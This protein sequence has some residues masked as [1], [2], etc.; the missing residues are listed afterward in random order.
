MSKIFR[1]ELLTYSYGITFTWRVMNVGTSE[2]PEMKYDM[3]GKSKFESDAAKWQTLR[4]QVF[5]LCQRKK[6]APCGEKISKKYIYQQKKGQS[7]SKNIVPQI[8]PWSSEKIPQPGDEF[9]ISTPPYPR[10]VIAVGYDPEH[11]PFG[12][13]L[14]NATTSSTYIDVVCGSPGQLLLRSFIDWSGKRK[15]RLSSILDVIQ[16]YP[17]FGFEFGKCGEFTELTEKVRSY[18]SGTFSDNEKVPKKAQSVI[19]YMRRKKLINP[20]L[21]NAECERWGTDAFLR[22][23][24]FDNGVKMERCRPKEF[25]LRIKD[26]TLRTPGRSLRS[27][28][29][30]SSRTRSKRRTNR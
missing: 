29:P 1:I 13:M 12:F 9:A 25:Q 30:V 21:N 28:R 17:K 26:R 22:N 19:Q 2:K 23:D 7:I 18:P 20:L 11:N 5:T 24:C 8:A 15:V 27:D 16:Y 4:E 6:G 3:V 14:A 10:N